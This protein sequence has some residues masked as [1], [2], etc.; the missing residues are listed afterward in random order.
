MKKFSLSDYRNEPKERISKRVIFKDT[1]V[2]AFILNISKNA[3]LPNHTH[4]TSTLLMKVLQG[5]AN[6]TINDKIVPLTEGELLQVEGSE[7]MSV[8][9]VGE[10]TL[11]LFI[12][13]SPT[14]TA[15]DYAKDVDM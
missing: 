5:T 12:T 2:L 11:Q 13:L 9:N 1:N 6:V 10:V 7:N 3:V 14:P 15:V 8:E 4:F